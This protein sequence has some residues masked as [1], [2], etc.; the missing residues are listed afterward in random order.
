MAVAKYGKGMVMAVGDP[1]VYNEYLNGRL[2][3]DYENDKAADDV[4]KWLISNIPA[5]K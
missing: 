5:K 2:P 3:A 1:W 4:I